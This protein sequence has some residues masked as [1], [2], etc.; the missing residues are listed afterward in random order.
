MT[1]QCA[2]ESTGRRIRG[3]LSEAPGTLR[4]ERIRGVSLALE[5]KFMGK[6]RCE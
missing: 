5:T 6:T 4:W 2:T 1:I 3:L